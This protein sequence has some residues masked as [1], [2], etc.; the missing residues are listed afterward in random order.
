MSSSTWLVDTLNAAAGI[1]LLA[2]VIRTWYWK[3]GRGIGERT[4]VIL[5]GLFGFSIAAN[6]V[7]FA[8]QPETPSLAAWT[9]IPGLT[10]GVAGLA[11]V[12]RDRPRSESTDG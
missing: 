10:G 11:A 5:F 3:R 7:T 2:A 6:L 9:F 4:R 12:I 1:A 8:L